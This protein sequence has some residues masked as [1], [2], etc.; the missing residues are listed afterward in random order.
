MTINLNVNPYYDDFVESKNYVKILFKPGY[1]VQA[2][3]LTQLQ[4]AL[5]KQVSRFGSHIFKDGSIVLNG[6]TSHSEISWIDVDV[7]VNTVISSAVN[8]RFSGQNSGAQGIV[9]RAVRKNDTIARLYFTYVTGVQFERDETIT[10]GTNAFTVIDDEAFAGTATLYSIAD[11]VFYVK[12]HFV[13]CES[14]SII[15]NESDVEMPALGQRVGLDIA[16]SI[17]TTSEDETLLDPA[18]GSY[19]FS[20]PGADRYT[21]SLTLNSYFYNPQ[22][23]AQAITGY[24]S[25][26][27]FVEISRFENNSLVYNITNAS[28]SDL[29]VNLARRTYDESGDYTV[30]PF[31]VKVKDHIYGEADK[32]TLSIEPGKAY[33][34]GYEFE[35]IATVNIDLDKAR[36][37]STKD[38]YS[39]QVDYGSYYLIDVPTGGQLNYITGAVALL[40]QS[41][42]QIGTANVRG[43]DYYT[44]GTYR[45][46][47]SNLSI[48]SSEAANVRT[49]ESLDSN[50]AASIKTSAVEYVNGVNVINNQRRTNIVPLP[51]APIKT[52]KIGG[53]SQTD[54]TAYKSYTINFIYENSNRST[55]SATGTVGSI[56]GT[57]PWTAT[58]TGMSSTEGL[59]VGTAFEAI[60]GTGSVGTAG[61]YT[62]AS[63][64]SGTSI[65]FTATGGSTPIAGS[66]TS[67]TTGTTKGTIAAG[68]NEQLTSTIP[69]DYLVTYPD[70][71][72]K[73]ITVGGTSSNRDLFIKGAFQETG[74]NVVA[75]VRLTAQV[76]RKKTLTTTTLTPSP[77]ISTGVIS[78][79]VADCYSLVKVIARDTAATGPAANKD[80][81]GYFEFST[82]QKDDVYDHGWIKLKDGLTIPSEYDVLDITFQYF[83]HDSATGFFSVDSYSDFALEDIPTYTA[84][85][86]EVYRLS[87]CLDFRSVR[88]AGSSTQF[89]GPLPAIPYED[90]QC[91]YEYYLPRIDKLVLTKERKF[92]VIRGIPADYPSIPSDLFDAMTLYVIKVPAYTV[93]ADDVDASY[94]DNR[95]YTMR[96]IGRIEKRVER[97]EYYTALSLLEKQAKD[98]TIYDDTGVNERFKNG[99]L[100]DSFSG[101]AV[102]DVNNADYSCAI[103]YEGRT[104]RPRF[105]PFSFGYTPNTLS[106]VKQRGDLITLNYTTETM[107]DQPYATNTVNL[108]PYFVFAWNGIVTLD[109]ATDTWVDTYTKPDVTV[110][111][112]G[113]NDVFTTI[114]DNVSNP[115]SLG[116]R[117]N[118]WQV[119]GRGVTTTDNLS[120]SSSTSTSTVDGRILETTRDVVT[121]NQTTTVNETLQRSG[122]AIAKSSVS[123]VTSDLGTRVV[124]VSIVPYIRSRIVKFAAKNLKPSTNLMAFFDSIDVSQY[125]TP[126]DEIIFATNTVVNRTSTRVR[127]KQN[128]SK[129][130][131]VVLSKNDRIFV[132]MDAGQSLFI[133][134]EDEIEWQIGSV[135][136][137]SSSGVI[138]ATVSRTSLE[139]NEVGD[140]AG[141][142]LIP[143]SEYARFRIGEKTFRLADSVGQGATTAAE[144][145]YVA[146]GLSQSVERTI[147]AT[148]VASVSINPTQ[149]TT[150]RTSETTSSIVV[151][152]TSVTRD[153]TPPPP[154]LPPPPVMGCGQ[155]ENGRGQTGRFTYTLNFGADVGE[156][157]I[158]FT[159]SDVPDRYTIIWDGNEYTSGFVGNPSF[160]DALN[161]LGF[162]SITTQN[163]TENNRIVNLRFNKTKA[164]PETATLIIEAPLNGTGWNFQTV[165][166]EIPVPEVIPPI[167]AKLVT[168]KI[169]V[170]NNTSTSFTNVILRWVNNFRGTVGTKLNANSSVN[171]RAT[172]KL[173]SLEASGSDF[174]ITNFQ[175]REEELRSRASS[176]SNSAALTTADCIFSFTLTPEAIARASVNQ[177]YRTTFTATWE[178]VKNDDDLTPE[179]DPIVVS[180]DYILTVVANPNTTD[181][182]AQTFFV[183]AATYPNGVFVDSVDLFFKTKSDFAPVTVQLRPTVNGYPS[184]NTVMPFGISTLDPKDINVPA[185]STSMPAT[186]FQFE[187]IVHLAPGEYSFVVLTNST[188]YEMYTARLGEFSLLDDS[189]RVTE[190]KVLGSMFKSQNSTTWTPIQEEDV[191]FVLNKCVFD[192]TVT[193]TAT[194]DT[195]LPASHTALGYDLFYTMGEVIDFASTNID[196]FYNAQ[197]GGWTQYQLGSNVEMTSRKTLTNKGDLQFRTVLTT[198]DQNITPVIDLNRLSSV[199]VQNVVNNDATGETS[200]IGGNAVARYITRRVK[201]NP[202]FEARDLK[203]YFNLNRPSGTS[204]KVYY[205][206]A[207]P[208]DTFFGDNEYVEMVLESSG[209]YSETGYPEQRY[210]T[211]FTVSDVSSA[212]ADG[213]RFDTFAIKIVMLSETTSKVP[214]IRDLR[215][216]ALDD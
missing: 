29:E 21:I 39:V 188:D 185:N 99:I 79:N 156:C 104:V 210:K 111:L 9:I 28:Y 203:V 102:G 170:T 116:V 169:W 75:R 63:I 95:R 53:N 11:S 37:V 164:S 124:D 206:V 147:V 93:K 105:A 77:A 135:W 180:T 68:S 181:P 52:L 198:L 143:N 19:N 4:T 94:I 35:T 18:Q 191:K 24:P 81:T 150:T 46:Y 6:Q 78:L 128:T 16:E 161:S 15:L 61:L 179:F 140:V 43:I 23:P 48:S 212:F 123:T 70:G 72:V 121:N 159:S 125:C 155:A 149:E 216:I 8:K 146:S 174:V 193:G 80:V 40:N 107:I 137:T 106:N 163:T 13:F 184:A 153:I 108:N 151:S 200:A 90:V 84:S 130:A 5:Q 142:F 205:K 117:W 12:G 50:W 3:E 213:Q 157:G 65:T 186:R 215:V 148:R 56:S 66:I 204:V 209:T 26:G 109:P 82:G 119:T 57:G 152:D 131:T 62:V 127:S 197:A 92:D 196:Y 73:T 171:Q 167:P 199:L 120:N 17:V 7:T 58:I 86:G 45:L 118:D 158:S 165:C 2:R 54:Y 194:L 189:V 98:E 176:R 134:G 87:D 89:T 154:V 173:V 138:S 214:K 25:A 132:V 22:F 76:E 122:I 114:T 195:A 103:D 31:K 47:V 42:A 115:A 59:A 74:V 129:Q 178:Y 49:I 172:Y 177:I 110:N 83:E 100:V 20:A 175:Q 33:V 34:K 133:A 97:V 208:S 201:L 182:V 192:T 207:A 44:T 113:E 144:C 187:N 160:N 141:S 183:D 38:E 30:R 27:E 112:N 60:A 211:P 168:G 139:T 71:S 96:D 190:Q 85:N 32:L 136:L 55:I 14:Q 10:S 51:N 162:P 91:D 36:D 1:A 145:K 126:A 88:N 67:I 166:P 101:H 69:T 41:N 202:G 64:V